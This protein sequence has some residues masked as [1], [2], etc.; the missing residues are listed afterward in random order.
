MIPV[1]VTSTTPQNTLQKDIDNLFDLLLSSEDL[2]ETVEGFIPKTSPCGTLHDITKYIPLWVVY[3][4]QD[5]ESTG[6]KA[7]S[8]FDFLQKYYDWLYCDTEEGAQYTLSE[9]LLDLI[10]VETTKTKFYENFAFTYADGFDVNLLEKNGGTVSN[11]NFIKFIKSIR[12]NVHQRKTTINAIKY[13]FVSLFG[14]QNPNDIEVYEPKR[15]IL[16]LNGGAFPND[17]F[18]FRNPGVT[19][20]YNDRFD[21]AGS[22]LNG[23]RMQD[24]DWIQDYSYLLKVGR[25]ADIYRETYSNMMHPAGIRVVFEK[26]I[27]D[28][29]GPQNPDITQTLS[30][31]PQ[32]GNYGPYQFGV[33]YSAGISYVAG[34]TLYGLSSCVGCTSGY[35][36]SA[37]PSGVA[38]HFF[39]KWSGS[40]IQ[41]NFFFINIQDLFN[42][43]YSEG[44][45]SPNQGLTCGNCSP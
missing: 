32:I 37:A 16:R 44:F 34:V 17:K 33:T 21:L 38:T 10:D 41:S 35:G 9:K 22:Y 19:G 24:S 5:I 36:W 7:I 28:Y 26:T 4:K 43:Y 18:K 2:T 13:F 15:N 39:P 29:Q 40:I 25:T 23:S 27:N 42:I 12:K 6:E 31:I 11:E 1:V 14:I 45:T 3:E 30:E 20:E 8:V